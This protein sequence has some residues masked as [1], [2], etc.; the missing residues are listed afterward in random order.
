MTKKMNR[1]KAG[2]GYA[3]N[4]IA[5]LVNAGEAVILSMVVTRTN[6]LADAGILS[7]AFAI[8][9]LMMTIGKFGVRNFQ[10]TD[11]EEK[12]SFADYFWA[13]VITTGWMTVTSLA[14]IYYCIQEKGYSRSKTVV[15]LAI[16]F[17]YAV[18]SVEDVFWG[19]YQ[20]KQALDAGAKI[21]FFRWAAI[22]TVFILVLILYQDLCMAAVLG[23][24]ICMAVFFIYNAAVFRTYDE[25]IVR[26]HPVSVYQVLRQCTPLFLVSFLSFY[27]INAPKYA[28]DR[29]MTEEVQACYGF[30][31]MPVFVI[32]LLN[33]FI[34]QPTLVQMALE[35]K[36]GRLAR[37]KKRMKRQCIILAGLTV[38]CLVGA[39]LC[40]IPVLSII[41]GTDL[42]GYKVELLILL[43]GGGIHALVGYLC[44]LLT[45]MRKQNWIMYGYA[46]AAVLAFCF[47]NFVVEH[48]AVLGAALFYVLLMI[49]LVVYF[50]VIYKKGL[51]EYM[52]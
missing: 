25:K 37:F 12:F 24:L 29:Y 20:Q 11:L 16:C 19:L 23:L 31:A 14:Y 42:N 44:V 34:Y 41:Y 1:G 22:L 7:I 6:G 15:I 26:V 10:V 45:I 28:I 8:G 4:S 33:G 32:G 18:E 43:F 51:Q 47:F 2:N 50:A 21:F 17:I 5:G 27:V 52:K 48:Y 49:G 46:G 3:W 38:V 39:F 40:G 9:N 35:W 30:V 36:D 13:R